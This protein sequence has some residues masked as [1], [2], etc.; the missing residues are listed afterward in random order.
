M[1]VLE[2]KKMKKLIETYW[3]TPLITTLVVIAAFISVE[4][5]LFPLPYYIGLIIPYSIIANI[6]VI[7][8]QAF[9]RREMVVKTVLSSIVPF[10][11][12]ILWYI[13]SA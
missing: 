3:A 6:L 12:G 5:Q 8:Y 11:L 2:V 7:G 13:Q 10:C 9:F 1:L 4:L